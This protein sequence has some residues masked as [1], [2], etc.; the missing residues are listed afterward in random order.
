MWWW[1]CGL[2]RT[3]C[4]VIALETRVEKRTSFVCN[5]ILERVDIPRIVRAVFIARFF[6]PHPLEV[7]Q[8]AIIIVVYPP[9]GIIPPARAFPKPNRRRIIIIILYRTN[10]YRPIFTW[11]VALSTSSRRGSSRIHRRRRYLLAACLVCNI[12][13][14]K[15]G[16]ARTR[17]TRRVCFSRISSDEGWRLHRLRSLRKRQATVTASRRNSLRILYCYLPSAFLRNRVCV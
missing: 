2:V 3:M 10:L 6:S 17:N 9:I 12:V 14:C 16:R 8:K 5:H 7:G 11:T 1:W 13:K 4:E 15:H